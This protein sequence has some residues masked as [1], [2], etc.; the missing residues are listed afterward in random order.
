MGEN[1]KFLDRV[2][3]LFTEPEDPEDET[4]E[5]NP[6]GIVVIFASLK[7]LTKRGC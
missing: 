1:M 6:W 7:V 2:K 4:P 5:N 3:N